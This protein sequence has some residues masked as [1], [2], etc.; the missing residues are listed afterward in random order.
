[1]SA[2]RIGPGERPIQFDDGGGA[3]PATLIAR[4]ASRR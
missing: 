3:N 4:G 1:M 2:V